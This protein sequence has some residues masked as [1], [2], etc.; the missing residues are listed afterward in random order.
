MFYEKNIKT[1]KMYDVIW[2]PFWNF[3]YKKRLPTVASVAT[4]LESF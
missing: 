2:R 3:A 4:T 1:S